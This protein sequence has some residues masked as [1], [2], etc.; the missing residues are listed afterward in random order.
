MHRRHTRR[1]VLAIY[2][3]SQAGVLRRRVHSAISRFVTQPRIRALVI[4]GLRMHFR[5][6][7][8]EELRRRFWTRRR[9]LRRGFHF[10]PRRAL[11]RL[12]QKPA[13]FIIDYCAWRSS[14]FYINDLQP[15]MSPQNGK[16]ATG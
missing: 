16:I 3:C 1:K 7:W 5:M 11:Q 15:Q 2:L 8:P 9:R 12:K 10:A 6:R 4:N 14:C 13:D